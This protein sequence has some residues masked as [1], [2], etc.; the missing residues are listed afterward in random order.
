[1]MMEQKEKLDKDISYKE[2][3]VQIGLL[4]QSDLDK[5]KQAK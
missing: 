4:R 3:M 1:M 5:Y 2:Y